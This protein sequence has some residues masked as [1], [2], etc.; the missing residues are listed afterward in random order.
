MV[1]AFGNME[2]DPEV[3]GSLTQVIA[4]PQSTGAIPISLR[5]EEC[6]QRV[7]E[8][9][10]GRGGFHRQRKPGLCKLYEQAKAIAQMCNHLPP[11]GSRQ[12]VQ[13]YCTI[14]GTFCTTVYWSL[15]LKSSLTP[16]ITLF[17][18]SYKLT[19]ETNPFYDSHKVGPK[20]LPC[21]HV[22]SAKRIP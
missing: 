6:K 12:I 10:E 16:I 13:E 3:F 8:T 5:G 19:G 4:I 1:L 17:T 21:P 20:S 7:L 11:R 15:D 22:R 9:S 14:C 2:R 18:P